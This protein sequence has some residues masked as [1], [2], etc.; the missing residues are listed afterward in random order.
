MPS[1]EAPRLLQI[2]QVLKSNGTEGELVWGFRDFGPEDIDLEEPVFIEYD[3]LPVPFFITA[4]TPRGNSKALVRLSDIR[5]HEEAEEIVGKAV[6]VPE[7]SI[8]EAEWEEGDPAGLVGWT[9][10]HAD[11]RKA[12]VITDFEDIPGNPCLYVE[13][14]EGEVMLPLHEDLIR[15]LDPEREILIMD[16]PAGLIP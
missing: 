14:P 1:A 3:G 5:S 13:G 4:L 11:G 10:L 16:I 7:D 12:G 15:E 9:L 8:E 6:C 2:A